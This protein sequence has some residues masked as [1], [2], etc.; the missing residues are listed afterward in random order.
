MQKSLTVLCLEL[1]DNKVTPLGCEFLGKTLTPGPTCP[2]VMVLKL[3]HNLF[4]SKGCILLSEGLK[5]NENLKLLSL[6][7]CDID[8]EGARSLFEILIFQKSKL[9]ELILT[10]NHFRNEGTK[11]I[12]NGVSIEKELKKIYLADNQFNE[13]PDMLE[14]IKTCMTRNKNLARYDFRYNDLLDEAVIFFTEML[15]PEE[16][17]KISHVTEIEISERAT[18][19]KEVDEGPPAKFETYIKLFKD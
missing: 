14:C 8:A 19:K 2:P 12:L 11:T 18:G 9:E 3:D 15:G 1:L 10:G 16:E 7:Y 6:C 13:E 4:G 17:G 5:T